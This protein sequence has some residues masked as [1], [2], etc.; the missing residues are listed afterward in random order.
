MDCDKSSYKT[1]SSDMEGV[2]NK[3]QWNK[4]LLGGPKDGLASYLEPHDGQTSTSKYR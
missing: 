2:L 4:I 3:R 1:K